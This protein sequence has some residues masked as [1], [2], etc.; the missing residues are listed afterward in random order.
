[1]ANLVAGAFLR[2]LN[3]TYFKFENDHTKTFVH[4]MNTLLP[5]GQ[6]LYASK[7]QVIAAF[8]F[9][10][11]ERSIIQATS[12]H[13]TNC[14]EF[15][16]LFIFAFTRFRLQR[17]TPYLLHRLLRHHIQLVFPRGFVCEEEMTTC[18][19]SKNFLNNSW[20]W[21]IPLLIIF[22]VHGIYWMHF[23]YFSCLPPSTWDP[24]LPNDWV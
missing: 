14:Q 12:P 16:P 1:M 24:Q 2:T 23:L 22:G 9:R 19:H 11:K 10:M 7:T 18:H 15:R 5:S 8:G 4:W 20:T 17:L 13:I 21:I 6:D 3:C